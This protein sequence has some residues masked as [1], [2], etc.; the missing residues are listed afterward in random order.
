[1]RASLARTAAL[2]AGT[3]PPAD[4]RP[5]QKPKPD[6]YDSR[7]EATPWGPARRLRPPASID[8]AIMRWDKPAAALGSSE[9]RW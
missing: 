5:L 9:P 6:D 2:L 1:M 3:P 8:G 7:I 4:I